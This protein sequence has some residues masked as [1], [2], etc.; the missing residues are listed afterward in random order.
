MKMSF[1]IIALPGEVFWYYNSGYRFSLSL[2]RPNRDPDI[3][4]RHKDYYQALPMSE[5]LNTDTS[6][7]FPIIMGTLPSLPVLLLA[8]KC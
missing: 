5:K 8:V 4:G 1:F 2:H 7:C 3:D 6:G